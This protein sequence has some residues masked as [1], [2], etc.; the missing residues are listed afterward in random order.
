[1]RGTW[2]REAGEFEYDDNGRPYWEMAGGSGRHRYQPIAQDREKGAMRRLE[3]IVSERNKRAVE[4]GNSQTAIGY[5]IQGDPRGA[6]LYIL[7]P[8][9][10]PEG[11]DA[12]SYYNRGV[13]VY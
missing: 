4:P 1:M 3:Q 9:D 13:V 10:V 7:R 5:Y 8:G 6:A 12:G 11:K 2:N